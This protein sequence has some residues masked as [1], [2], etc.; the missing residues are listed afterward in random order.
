[1]NVGVLTSLYPGPPR[2]FEGVFAERRWTGMVGRGHG[3]RV[4]QPLPHTPGPLARGRWKE[5]AGFP[6]SEERKGIVVRRPRYW[7]WPGRDLANQRRFVKAGLAQLLGEGTP[8]VVVADYAWPAAGAAHPLAKAGVPFVVNGRGSDVLQVAGEAG[9]GDELAALLRTAG[10]WCAVSQDLVDAMDRLAGV[11]GRGYLVP[12]GVDFEL[13][14]PRPKEEG[15]RR[16]GLSPAGPLVLVAGHLIERKDPLLALEVFLAGAPPA[17]QLVFVGRGPLGTE[18]ARQV[19]A[20]SL[21]DKVQLV[22]EVEPGG[23]AD[24]YAACDVLLLTSKREGRPNVVLEAL[25]SG[26]AVLATAAGGTAELLAPH[27][28]RMLATH[29]DP[30]RLGAMLADLLEDPPEPSVLREGV[31]HLSWDHSLETLE[32]CLEQAREGTR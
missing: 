4:V 24:W 25:A 27:L 23:L 28:G 15:R 10:N 14:R 16:L 30:V 2:P 3:V 11:P 8:D 22:G 6:R 26:R 32:R 20:R 21:G 7:H 18:L 5:I 13:F 17:A 1:M 19:K 29:R 31:Q 9:L 12:N